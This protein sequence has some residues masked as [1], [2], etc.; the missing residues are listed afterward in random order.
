MIKRRNKSHA[1]IR[2]GIADNYK[3]DKYQSIDIQ[4]TGVSLNRVRT[5]NVLSIIP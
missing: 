5:N 2:F 3:I 4:G 1:I